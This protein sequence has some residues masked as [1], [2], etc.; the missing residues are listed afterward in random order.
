MV[1]LYSASGLDL[2]AGRL[3]AMAVGEGPCIRRSFALVNGISDGRLTFIFYALPRCRVAL[4]PARL[5]ALITWS[6]HRNGPKLNPRSGGERP[7]G[8]ECTVHS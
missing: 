1:F 7:E 8:G 6:G 2:G 4:L 5:E 3:R